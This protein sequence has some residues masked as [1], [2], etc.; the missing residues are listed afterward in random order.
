M[1][2]VPE[3]AYIYAARTDLPKG[4]YCGECTET[5]YFADDYGWFCIG[6]LPYLTILCE[7]CWHAI[8]CSTA[9]R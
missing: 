9:E 3:L 5:N 6:R 4:F 2:T 7:R 1:T 8:G